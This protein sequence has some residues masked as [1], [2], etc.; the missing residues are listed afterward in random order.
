[1]TAPLVA[2]SV[3]LLLVGLVTAWYVQRLQH[4]A[5]NVV[6][7]NVSSIRAAEELAI[8]LREIRN[9]INQ[10]LL[11][12]DRR[13]LDAVPALR[14]ETDRW[15][16]EA[17]R[18]A[19]THREQQSM[20]A[21]EHG[22][23]QFLVQFQRFHNAEP[24]PESQEELRRLVDQVLTREILAPAHDYLDYNEYE[25]DASSRRGQAMARRMV[26]GLLLLSTCGPVAGLLAGFVVA[27]RV[28][29][30][31]VELSVPVR[32]A[33]GQL[34]EV[35]GPIS[36][37]G[38]ELDEL[39]GLMQRLASQVSIVVQRLQQSQRE[40]LRNEQ[41]AAVGQL[42]AGVAHELR[43]PLQSMQL[44]VQSA[45]ADGEAGCLRGRDLTVLQ[46]AVD[47]LKRSVQTFLD[48]ARPPTLDKQPMDLGGVVRQ[49]V[50]LVS[51]RASYQDVRIQ[52]HLPDRPLIIKADLDQ[53]RQVVLNL[54]L[55]AID[56]VA[57]AGTVTVDLR[58][59][60]SA[61]EGAPGQTPPMDSMEASRW[62]TL[63]VSDDGCGLPAGLGERIF[64]PFVTTKETGIGLGLAICRRI[65][66]AHG[67]RLI[68][69]NGTLG[70]AVLTV[71][72]PI[73]DDSVSTEAAG[74]CLTAVVCKGDSHAH[75][76]GD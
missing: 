19:T 29:R 55:N 14:L 18:L 59:S 65:A 35:V 20:T 40:V 68:A 13:H 45:V 56:A 48:F 74:K 32:D 11:S 2:V 73:A 41:L 15:L 4:D 17:R 16:K 51:A 6:A 34:S 47:R 67:G 31:L 46:E 62:V 22:Y 26:L 10:F 8:G 52:C 60:A 36:A 28:S 30:T 57:A 71:Q 24:D 66:E 5:T 37:A 9:Q 58:G 1:M 72:L 75:A 44:L 12:G 61:A 54:L 53:M 43:N 64:E 70:G 27:R 69:A 50:E 25:I 38:R 23:A 39:P 3:L 21:V 42:A 7:L 63:V 49:T 33:A 76:A